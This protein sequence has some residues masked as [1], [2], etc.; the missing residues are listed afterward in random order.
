MTAPKSKYQKIMAGTVKPIREVNTMEV[1]TLKEVP[2][3]PH[4]MKNEEAQNEWERLAPVFIA[5]GLL[6]TAN[7]SVL[8]QLCSLHGALVD[9]WAKGYVPHAATMGQYRSMVNDFGLTPM[10][11]MRVK[12]PKAEQ[13][14][15]SFTSNGSAPNVTPIKRA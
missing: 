12:M 6:T 5:N 7:V 4:W 3:W 8:A 15:N 9:S 11:M 10:A 2:N 1:E 13:K 14:K